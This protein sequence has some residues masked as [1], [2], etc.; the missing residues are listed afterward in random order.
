MYKE[1][2]CD[3]LHRSNEDILCNSNGSEDK[4]G[5]NIVLSPTL[6]PLAC[7]MSLKS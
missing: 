4:N 2:G 7:T 3:N 1:N 6:K 5:K